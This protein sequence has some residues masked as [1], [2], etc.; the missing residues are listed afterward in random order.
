MAN[1]RA[2]SIPFLLALLSVPSLP[3]T[4]AEPASDWPCQQI[5]VPALSPAQ[6]WAGDPIGGKEG[7]WRDVAGLEPVLRQAVD[8]SVDVEAAEEAIDRYAGSLGPDR[9]AVLTILF[10]GVFDTLNRQRSEAISAIQRYTRQQRAMLDRI[11]EELTRMQ[12]LPPRS[13]EAESLA[14]EISWQ[15]RVLDERRRY[16]S[17]LCDQPVRMEQRVGRLARAIGAHLD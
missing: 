5:L 14:R 6:I 16:Q 12:S 3:A 9:N 13:P 17:A 1:R 11:G 10:A 8:G 7:A 15:R 4:A 2:L